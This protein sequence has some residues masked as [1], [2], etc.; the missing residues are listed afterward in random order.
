MARSDGRLGDVLLGNR[1]LELRLDWQEPSG[2]S[3]VDLFLGEHI[4]WQG[5]PSTGV[6]PDEPAIGLFTTL[7]GR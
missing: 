7:K 1:A 3:D 6:G 5:L 4:P 2:P